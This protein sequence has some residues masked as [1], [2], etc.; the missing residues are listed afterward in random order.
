MSEKN[1]VNVLTTLENASVTQEGF[2]VP[3]VVA[4]C[5]WF[6]DTLVRS[7]SDTADMITDG[8][9]SSSPEVKAVAAILA[10]NPKVGSVRVGRLTSQP[11]QRV[12]ITPT[13]ANNTLY[14]LTAVSPAGAAT[15][16]QFTSDGTATL[17]EIIAG[18]IAALPVGLTG[19]D[20]TTYMR[21]Q[22]ST[23]GNQWAFKDFTSNL[24]FEEDTAVA[25]VMADQ[26]TALKNA[27]QDWYGFVLASKGTPE[28][29]AAS[30]WA[31]SNDK[32]FCFATQNSDVL[33][34]STSNVIA[35]CKTANRFR[36]IG[37]RFVNVQEHGDA[38][39]LG[40][41]FPYDPGSETW[42][43]KT[44]AGISSELL[45]TTERNFLE[46]HNGGS[47]ETVAGSSRTLN[48]KVTAGEWIDVIR[49]RDWV[50]ARLREAV[51]TLLFSKL[52]VPYTDVGIASIE[53]EVRAVLQEATEVGGLSADPAFTV[54][55]PKAKDVSSADKTARRLRNVNW[56]ATLAGAIHL[57]DPLNGTLSV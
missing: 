9:T 29:E 50:S 11:T 41:L 7:Y 31:E 2:G 26:L 47:Y 38:A 33:T 24:T 21:A 12:K 15:V 25:G 18:L 20:Q 14:K 56:S 23:P 39:F 28:I 1:I 3:M 32:L 5:S 52:K 13:V 17:T 30:A 49:F 16:V 19:S 46:G 43:Y 10:Q 37:R 27:N 8:A 54:S 35:V 34:S 45:S 51:L 6:S 22:A 53:A 48:S 44:L 36:T 4:Y 57:V 42:E 40:R 55:V